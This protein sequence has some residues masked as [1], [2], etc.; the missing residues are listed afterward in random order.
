V[1]KAMVSYHFGGKL[2]LYRAIF[3]QF[4]ERGVAA[5]AAPPGDART[6][7]ERLRA[8]IAAWGTFAV[9]EPAFPIL[10]SRETLAAGRH[11]G[12]AELPRFLAVFGAVREL[13]KLGES[14]GTLH[15]DEPLMTHLALIGSLIFFYATAPFR[16]MVFRRLKPP[17][18]KPGLA[19]YVTFLQDLYTRALAPAA[20]KPAA[21]APRGRGETR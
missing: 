5:L 15:T 8:F 10:V 9:E 13:F 7:V 1:N 19:E 3:R 16:E 4:L 11:L 17:V 21:P 14:D 12:D 6:A 2:G 20:A 18:A